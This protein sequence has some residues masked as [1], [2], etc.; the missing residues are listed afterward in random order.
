M[1]DAALPITSQKVPAP[2]RLLSYLHATPILFFNLVFF[3]VK[4]T[5]TCCTAACEKGACKVNG[6][7]RVRW[8]IHKHTHTYKKNTDTVCVNC[9]MKCCFNG[10]G[11]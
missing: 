9:D 8:L 1:R 4:I 5:V 11:K 3:K 10:S 7:C 2:C 6:T